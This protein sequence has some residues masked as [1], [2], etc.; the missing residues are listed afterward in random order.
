MTDSNI[1]SESVILGR[2]EAGLV[3]SLELLDQIHVLKRLFA[4]DATLWDRCHFSESELQECLAW[5]DAFQRAK[6]ALSSSQLVNFDCSKVV[7]IGMGGSS[8]AAQVY[9]SVCSAN[10]PLQV[11]SSTSPGALVSFLEMDNSAIDDNQFIVSSKSGSTIETI[12]I[13]KTLYEEQLAH[14]LSQNQLS[15]ITDKDQSILRDWAEAK[16]F[17][18][19]ESDSHVPGRYSALSI[20]GLVPAAILGCDITRVFEA[21]EKRVAEL[22]SDGS[23]LN[24][25]ISVLAA[26]LSVLSDDAGGEIILE[27]PCQLIPLARW[28]EQLVAESL[29]K[30]GH[31]VLPVIRITPQSGRQI[32]VVAKPA[33]QQHTSIYSANINDET[34]LAETFL[35]WQA[36][37]VAAGWLMGINPFDQPDVEESKVLVKSALRSGS[38]FYS[39]IT[40]KSPN[41]EFEIYPSGDSVE[42]FVNAMIEIEDFS[43]LSIVA[44]V[45]PTNETERALYLLSDAL[46]ALVKRTVI[47]NFGP[48][49]LHSTGQ[50]HKGGPKTGIYLILTAEH[51]VDLQ[52]SGQTYSFGDLSNIQAAIDANQLEKTQQRVYRAKLFGDAKVCVELLTREIQASIDNQSKP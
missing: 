24:R 19:F 22:V 49:Y 28:I 12:G 11:F 21:C 13:A 44:F 42:T 23:E 18:I 7:L 14:R 38:E 3:K 47:Y 17:R 9:D 20:L 2:L 40:P 32:N 31:G 52:V 10:R 48:Q 16:R 27:V 41:L 51:P 25:A 35:S 45:E 15:V 4:K 33:I 50:F 26:A 37:T 29:G 30:N 6:S 36:A 1:A 46:S 39:G 34:D 8:L 5:T 43:Y